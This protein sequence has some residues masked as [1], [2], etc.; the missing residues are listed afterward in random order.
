MTEPVFDRLL[1]KSEGHQLL[2]G[3]HAVLAPNQ[4]PYLCGISMQHYRGHRPG[5]AAA[6]GFSPLLPQAAG[7]RTR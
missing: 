7:R 1:A 2:A 4:P 3:N 5:N 6:E